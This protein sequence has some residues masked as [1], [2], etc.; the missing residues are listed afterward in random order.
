[1][2]TM[3][4]L[5]TSSNVSE[6]DYES[7]RS[8]INALRFSSY[9]EISAAELTPDLV[10]VTEKAKHI[11]YRSSGLIELKNT[12]FCPPVIWSVHETTEKIRLITVEEIR[13]FTG[14]SS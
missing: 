11:K 10:S 3:S 13:N 14:L 2:P 5:F 6:L 1:M 8:L 9:P 12:F 4:N 7:F